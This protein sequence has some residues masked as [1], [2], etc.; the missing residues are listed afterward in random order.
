MNPDNP[1]LWKIP[2]RVYPMKTRSISSSVSIRR[3]A[4]RRAVWLNL[5]DN[6]GTSEWNHY[7]DFKARQ[8]PALKSV[9]VMM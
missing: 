4:L 9:I 8:E 7:G 1:S 3:T 2:E 5:P 6:C